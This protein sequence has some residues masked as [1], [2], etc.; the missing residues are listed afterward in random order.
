MDDEG[1]KNVNKGIKGLGLQTVRDDTLK[2]ET[3]KKD[4]IS[5]TIY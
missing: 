3:K 5:D 2:K 4:I 1:A